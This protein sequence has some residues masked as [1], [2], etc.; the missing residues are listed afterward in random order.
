MGDGDMVEDEN[1]VAPKDLK[2]SK[3]EMLFLLKHLAGLRK[4][5]YPANPIGSSYT[6]LPQCNVRA[7]S[8]AYFENVVGIAAEIDI[9]LDKCGLDGLLLEGLVTWELSDERLARA[10]NISV[11]EVNRRVKRALKYISSGPNVRWHNTKKRSG[12]SY[13][14][15]ISHRRDKRR[16][17]N[18]RVE[19]R[20]LVEPL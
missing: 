11:A 9:R 17:V 14:E 5:E 18:E 8:G 3:A 12:I 6:T 13:K 15:F 10:T 1:W 16:L 4:G 2:F 20:E 7:K 19:V